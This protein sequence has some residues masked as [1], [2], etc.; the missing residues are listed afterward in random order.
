MHFLYDISV[1]LIHIFQIINKKVSLGGCIASTYI[2]MIIRDSITAWS[3]PFVWFSASSVA[4]SFFSAWSEVTFNS[5]DKLA[6]C[7]FVFPSIS[8]L[9]L[10]S[11]IIYFQLKLQHWLIYFLLQL[12]YKIRTK[13]YGSIANSS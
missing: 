13:R 12:F 10:I 5:I 8:W 2:N 9:P 6:P 11:L 7:E 1:I 3:L 4:K